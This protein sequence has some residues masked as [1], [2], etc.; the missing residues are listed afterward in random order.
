[1]TTPAADGLK[2]PSGRVDR[3]RKR[4]IW[5]LLGPF[6]ILMSVATIEGFTPASPTRPLIVVV[7]LVAAA[8]LLPLLMAWLARA[9]LREAEALENERGE[10]SEL[11]GRASHEALVDGL[12]GLGNHRAFQDELA[13]QLDIAKRNRTPLALMLIDVD[14]L[15]R[16][17]DTHGHVGGDRLLE[18]V[19]RVTGAILRRSD[20]AFRVGG[21]EFAILLPNSDVETGLAVARR[22]LA[23]A[24]NGGDPSDAIDSFSLSI[25]V[26]AYPQPSTE[27][28]YLYRN[29]DAALY[30]C[31]R[32]GRTAVVAFDPGRHGTASDD[33]SVAELS[34]AVGTIIATR[35]LRPVYQ[36]IYSMTTGEPIGYEGLVRPAEGAP[37]ADA[38][39]LFAAAE[40]A[41]RTVELDLACLEIVA[42]GIKLPNAETY[43]SVNLS[44]RTLES[45]LFHPGELKAIFHRN[46]IPL[47]R[48][49]LEL[50]EREQVEDLQQLRK[51]VEACRRAGM[52]LAA[53][54]VGAGNAGLRLLSEIHFDI[55]KI[56]L[57]L[58]QGGT[59]HDPSHGVLRALQELATRW[60]AS[61]VAEG[62]ETAAQL[63]V[64]R[65]L[66]ISAGQGYL[67]ARPATEVNANA[68]DLAA[69]ESSDEGDFLR[70]TT[71][72]PDNQF[73]AQPRMPAA[74]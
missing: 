3:I 41:D 44:P 9:I 45:S 21:D 4:L 40:T 28:H 34:A 59:M 19:G 71:N 12:T 74:S 29:A 31:K 54:D 11:Y 65:S 24:L 56:D 27:S 17:N 37:F 57:S 6:A 51:N 61:I 5:A 60:Q 20:R 7:V 38:S 32:H 36:P 50:T 69:L 52:R 66:G 25:G 33:R 47:E 26:A 46:G 67:L 23:S 42:A 8:V 72:R 39:A 70:M 53:D 63:A 30:W 1:M 16:V 73:G 13:R 58:V 43:V 68:V 35:A 62:V 15:K 55:V 18:A 2:G 22:I 14:D 64:V 49:V 48:V 10:L